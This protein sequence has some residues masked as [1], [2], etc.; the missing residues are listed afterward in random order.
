MTA[1]LTA[2]ELLAAYRSGELSPVEATESALERIE[3]HD[4]EVNA[5]CLVDA[6][7]ALT[8]AKASAERWGAA[9]PSARWTASRSRSRTSC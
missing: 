2:T 5:F 6:D 1:H 9:S 3:R 8:S 7:A 4:P